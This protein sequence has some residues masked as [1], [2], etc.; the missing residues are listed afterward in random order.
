MPDKDTKINSD[1]KRIKKGNQKKEPAAKRHPEQR[2]AEQAQDAA[3]AEQVS[4]PDGS[5]PPQQPAA[6]HEAHDE[7]DAA[8]T[9]DAT[10]T[11][12][13]FPVICIGASAGGLQAL[14]SFVAELPADNG[15]AF[16]VITHTDPEHA[17]MLP[18]I[19]KKKHAVAVHLIEDGAAVEPNKI[20]IPL[21]I[22]IRSS[23]KV[24]FV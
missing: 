13:S 10:G 24:C 16:V 6:E 23:N 20:F 5:R 14:E 7:S 21:R 12:R 1:Q 8:A 18:E 15:I 9:S 17:S 3:F 11:G 19:I 2:Q 22:A 4:Q